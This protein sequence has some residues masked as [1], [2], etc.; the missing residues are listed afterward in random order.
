[1]SEIVWFNVRDVEVFILVSVVIIAVFNS[2]DMDESGLPEF[3]SG[4]VFEEVF[5]ESAVS[6][7]LV[8][9]CDDISINSVVVFALNSFEIEVIVVSDVVC[10]DVWDEEV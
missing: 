3:G 7:S 8:C 10:F 5:V 2:D 9:E 4:A 6:K 1:M